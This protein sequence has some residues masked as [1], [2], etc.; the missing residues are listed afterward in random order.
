M[1]IKPVTLALVAAVMIGSGLL[2]AETKGKPAATDAA[3]DAANVAAIAELADQYKQ[4]LAGQTKISDKL[5]K[6]EAD[7]D[8]IKKKS[9]GINRGIMR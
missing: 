1:T 8:F 9:V 3:A 7:V 5:D 2:L 4:L 6:L